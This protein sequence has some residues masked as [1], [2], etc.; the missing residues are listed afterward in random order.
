ML[1]GEIQEKIDY[2]ERFHTDS[3]EKPSKLLLTKGLDAMNDFLDWL[4]NIFDA[5][6]LETREEVFRQAEKDETFF[7]LMKMWFTHTKEE[8]TLD[9]FG[10]MYEEF[11]LSNLK[12]SKTGQFFTP[13]DLAKLMT[14][15]VEPKSGTVS[16]CCCGSGRLILPT[17]GKCDFAFCGDTDI[18]SVKMCALNLMVNE[19]QGIVVQQ[20]ALTLHKPYVGYLVNPTNYPFETGVLSIL[21][22]ESDEVANIVDWQDEK[23]VH[24]NFSRYMEYR[25]HI[26]KKAD[27]ML[28]SA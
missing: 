26:K 16:D 19:F 27:E 20:N 9:F 21:K 6:N 25:K 7:E 14:E 8:G 4:L 10:G 3:T 1:S 24:N 12:A 18:V 2:F 13:I 15:I 5:K 17:K 11:F 22:M 28:N 23:D